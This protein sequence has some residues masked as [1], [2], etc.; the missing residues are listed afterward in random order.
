MSVSL[1][2]IPSLLF[3]STIRIAYGSGYEE[4]V[5]LHHYHDSATGMP[6]CITY[7]HG[8]TYPYMEVSNHLS[9]S[10]SSL[11]LHGGLSAYMQVSLHGGL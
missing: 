7:L 4:Y 10:L 1:V 9:S 8:G 2:Y 11:S 5:K 6:E 3:M